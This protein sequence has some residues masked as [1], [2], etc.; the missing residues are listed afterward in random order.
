MAGFCIA[1]VVAMSILVGFNNNILLGLVELHATCY[2][3]LFFFDDGECN[4]I[5]RPLF[6]N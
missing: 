3:I 4:T 1:Y 2:M 6:S 5:S